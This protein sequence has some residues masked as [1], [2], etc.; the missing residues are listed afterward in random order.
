MSGDA[1]AFPECEVNILITHC[2]T[3][4]QVRGSGLS[5]PELIGLPGKAVTRYATR[6]LRFVVN[7]AAW[8]H[9]M[10]L[11]GRSAVV[12]AVGQKNCRRFLL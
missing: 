9:F 4:I 3:T 8:L 5:E 11:H 10:V 7:A 6:R 1:G 12:T 2:R